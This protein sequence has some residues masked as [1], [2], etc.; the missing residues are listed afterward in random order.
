M[1][2]RVSFIGYA[3][4]D[5]E[6]RYLPNGSAVATFSV[7]STDKWKDKNGEAQER[8]EWL[9]CNAFD[10]LADVCGEYVRKGQL[11][12][13]DGPLHTRKYTDKDG[14]ERFSTECRVQTLKLLGRRDDDARE[15]RPA[16]KPA[17]KPAAAPAT[18]FDDMDDDLPFISQAFAHDMAT[19]IERKMARYKL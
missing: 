14:V 11:V 10:R 12:Y 13:V 4:R 18:A 17:A 15:P 3:G 2:N 7:A 16:A 6:L 5:A 19:P 8:T 1:F 9:K